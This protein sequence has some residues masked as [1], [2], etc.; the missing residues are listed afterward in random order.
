M[1]I[2]SILALTKSHTAK[3]CHFLRRRQVRKQLSPDRY[4]SSIHYITEL[5][6]ISNFV[7]HLLHDY[8]YFQGVMTVI[9]ERR[10]RRPGHVDPIDTGTYFSGTTR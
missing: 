4:S 2:N 7:L 10:H 8:T 5:V 9:D 1:T 6:D 3:P